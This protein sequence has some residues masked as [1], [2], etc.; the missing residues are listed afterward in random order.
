[1]K[2]Y[3][4]NDVFNFSYDLNLITGGGVFTMLSS[5]LDAASITCEWL[6]SSNYKSL[7]LDYH[8]RSGKKNVSPMLTELMKVYTAQG[9]EHLP[10]NPAGAA[11]MALLWSRY[12]ANW[13]KRYAALQ[14]EYNPLEN[15]SM[16][17][18]ETVDGTN[19][20]TQ[21]TAETV[22]RDTSAQTDTEAT[23]SIYGYDSSTPSPSDKQESSV[24]SSGTEDVARN[25]TRTDNLAHS[26]D[27]ELTRAGN[28]GVTT[29]QQ[30]LQAELDIRMYDFFESVY[31]DID[32]VL[33]IPVY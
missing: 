16:V 12:G 5:Y 30:M 11:V 32:K 29:S 19:T 25:N 6:T 23:G 10:Y 22:D 21:A 7:D 14:T 8:S 26:E 15:Y 1:M 3:K 24:T 31:N 33:A 28:I 2:R 17:E 9:F 18:T 20:G 13:N 4:I 27:R